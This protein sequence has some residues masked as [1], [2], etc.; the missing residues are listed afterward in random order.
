MLGLYRR[1]LDF[2]AM[3]ATI[4][5]IVTL[6]AL[7]CFSISFGRVFVHNLRTWRRTIT[8]RHRR[9]TRYFVVNS[10]IWP[11]FGVGIFI[12]LVGIGFVL[13]MVIAHRAP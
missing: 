6:A 13:P 7:L 10:L 12:L 1:I 4:V 11:L 3:R 5:V 8:P 9:A 2:I